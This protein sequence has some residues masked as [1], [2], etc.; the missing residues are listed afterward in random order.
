M[1]PGGHLR[2]PSGAWPGATNEVLYV[3]YFY[4]PLV[5]VILRG[6]RAA[7]GLA[8]H[9][10]QSARR[11]LTG[12]P[13][14]GKSV[15]LWYI[16]YRLLTEQAHRTIVFVDG[17]RERV[18]VLQPCGAVLLFPFDRLREL[19]EQQHSLVDPVVLCD[20]HL[21]VLLPFP[22]IVVSSPGRLA[23]G[24]RGLRKE[25]MPPIYLPA[26][27]R[28]EVFDLRALAFSH[29]PVALVEQLVDMWGPIPRF[30]LVLVSSAAQ[31][32]QWERVQAVPL[33]D[34]ARVMRGA[35]ALTSAG[36]GDDGDSTHRIVIEHAACEGA[37]PGSHASNPRCIEFYEH[38][39]V[40]EA[41]PSILSWLVDRMVAASNWN[42]AFLVDSTARIAKLGALRG[43][44]FEPLALAVL[45]DGGKFRIRRLRG[46][47]VLTAAAEGSNSG[48]TV[49]A[50]LAGSASL[51][52]SSVLKS[53]SVDGAPGALHSISAVAA[54][55]D[56]T[57]AGASAPSPPV[58]GDALGMHAAAP[59]RLRSSS[60][61]P[62]LRAVQCDALSS[63]AGSTDESLLEVSAHN[64]RAWRRYEELNGKGVYPEM[65]VPENSNEAG[66]DA[67]LWLSGAG[68]HAPVDC[69]VSASH[70]LHQF[71]A[72]EAVKALGWTVEKGWPAQ[73][74]TKAAGMVLASPSRQL[75]V[76]YYWIVPEDV[77]ESWTRPQAPKPG[78]GHG[79]FATHLA[80]FVLCIPQL[81]RFK[82]LQCVLRDSRGVQ[83]PDELMSTLSAACDAAFP[84]ELR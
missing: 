70:G 42:A 25:F 66:L 46:N 34:I 21:P 80:Q 53:A 16:V 2:L 15:L 84:P 52:A 64:S 23:I 79:G 20:S 54:S 69:T 37:V 56:R 39:P 58:Q 62:G 68:H 43:L 48:S 1:L 29:V 83:H 30:C 6:C 32:A 4:A 47:C 36:A 24:E 74:V 10:L 65:L 17:L 22:T 44:T 40:T 75:Q 28:E 38:G 12:Q 49:G 26:P 27:S 63:N 31:R 7:P 33:E 61:N 76:Q 8:N 51:A 5:D 72:F 81:L 45:R 18:I 9:E 59:R 14:T 19:P 60:A 13:G 77:F 78:T 82:A 57:A 41:S 55:E 3:R 35:V 11:L 71:G 73:T 67:L 50:Y